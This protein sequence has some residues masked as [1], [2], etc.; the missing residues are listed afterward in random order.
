[1]GKYL[2]GTLDDQWQQYVSFHIEKLGCRLCRANRDDLSAEREADDN[3]VFR[4]RIFQS[5]VGFL[6]KMDR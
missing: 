4:K 3:S 2:L 1:V 5:T 6:K